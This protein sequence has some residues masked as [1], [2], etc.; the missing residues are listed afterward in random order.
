MGTCM[1]VRRNGGAHGAIVEEGHE[2]HTLFED[3]VLSVACQESE[4]CL[5]FGQAHVGG[6]VPHRASYSLA[7]LVLLV[8]PLLPVEEGRRV[9]AAGQN[10]HGL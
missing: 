9:V 3:G 4:R 7:I 5:C 1:C 2:R 6:E 10:S 8:A